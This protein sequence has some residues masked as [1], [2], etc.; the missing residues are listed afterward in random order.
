MARKNFSKRQKF[1]IL[2]GEMRT[3]RTSFRNTWMDLS[4]FILPRRGRFFV[5]DN[6]DG[7]T[8]RDEIIDSTASMASRTL[9][10]GMMTG[11]TSPA[12]PWFKLQTDIKEV[13]KAAAVKAYFD[14]VEDDMRN[15]FLKSNLYNVLPTLY[16]DMGTF[17][18]GCI[19]MEDDDED[20]VRFRG[21]PIGSY[22]V[23]NDHKGRA[24]V[25]FREFQMSVRQIVDKFGRINPLNPKKIDWSNI[26][27]RVKEHYENDQ[28]ETMIDIN[29]IVLPNEDYDPRRPEAKY[30][31]F[32]SCYYER[33]IS[34]VNNAAGFSNNNQED[35][36]L[37]ESG[38]D[39]FPA[40]VV[41][42]KTV[43][44]DV[45]GT[46]GPGEVCIGDVKQLQL[47]EKRIAMALEQK[48]RPSMV[49]P[50]SLRNAK[51]SILPGDITYLDESERNGGF[52]RLFE[53]D[54]DIRELEG[55]QQQIRE[56]ISKAYYEDL[57]LMLANS[58]R[59]QITATEIEERHEEKLLALG[60]VLESINQDLLDPLIE[61]TYTIMA[62]RDLLPDVPEELQG[63][64][65][66]IEYISIMAQAQKLA[67]I[68]HIERFLGFVGQL[69]GLD[70]M[71]ARK[72][73]LEEAIE[74]YGALTGIKP[75][76]IL[77]KEQMEAL[78]QQQAQAEQA[79]MQ[80]EQANQMVQTG[81][82][83]SETK[84]DEDTAL[85]QLLGGQG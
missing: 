43:G 64:D 14:E 59:R 17:S 38:Y 10:S 1:N 48:V 81:K 21:F 55:K 6:N 76:L 37:R 53:V 65:F 16:E 18:T 79:A 50:T 54:F 82:A 13:N 15:I 27:I 32:K 35:K 58:D 44:E 77:S 83:L 56:K 51:A 25:F 4:D 52:R 31:R 33:G 69:A 62:D 12:R 74:E 47:Q 2:E 72:V 41:R 45:Y 28:L 9:A 39:F 71:V 80:A 78:R 60:P 68:G 85:A 49:G 40:L 19:Y 61:N 7:D 57:F 24:R 34:S 66:N 8:K 20:V 46:G 3:E 70:P 42:W 84:M 63:L 23:A 26:S 29:H 75:K 5:T 30:K 73:D 11:V 22:M 36:F 67:G